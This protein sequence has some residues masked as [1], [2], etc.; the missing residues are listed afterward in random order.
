M[1]QFW[2]SIYPP[3]ELVACTHATLHKNVSLQ[4]WF[5]MIIFFNNKEDENPLPNWSSWMSSCNL[6]WLFFGTFGFLMKSFNDLKC[7]SGIIFLMVGSCVTTMNIQILVLVLT[8]LL[9]F[10]L[11]YIIFESIHALEMMN[12]Q[13]TLV[14][15]SFMLWI[16]Q[17]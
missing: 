5:C 8:T 9:V 6:A 12:H 7:V 14:S 2:D 17:K 16:M 11:Q 4:F 15:L 3:T 13:C 1:W 10:F